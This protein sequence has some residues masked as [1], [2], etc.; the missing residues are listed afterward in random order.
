MYYQWQ[1]DD[2]DSGGGGDDNEEERRRSRG[3]NLAE[4][5]AFQATMECD[6]DFFFPLVIPSAIFSFFFFLSFFVTPP[7]MHGVGFLLREPHNERF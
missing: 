1:C 4:N 6:C 5:L 2:D 7:C 3:H